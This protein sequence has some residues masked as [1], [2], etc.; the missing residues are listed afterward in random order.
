MWIGVWYGQ[1]HR[2]QSMP[3]YLPDVGL[4]STWSCSNWIGKIRRWSR[5]VQANGV[6]HSYNKAR[7][8][9]TSRVHD[10]VRVHR[11]LVRPC[12]RRRI[13]FDI[14]RPR[15][16][17]HTQSNTVNHPSFHQ[18][19]A[20]VSRGTRG[21]AFTCRHLFFCGD[22]QPIHVVRPRGVSCPNSSETVMPQLASLHTA[23]W[24]ISPA[25]LSRPL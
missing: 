2:R 4:D 7:L 17:K 11:E 1:P 13:V 20:V 21:K 14:H 6:A 22:D 19:L 12:C 24:V 8:E 25:V 5:H 10:K 18:A 15:G 23:V 16:W 3:A 9:H